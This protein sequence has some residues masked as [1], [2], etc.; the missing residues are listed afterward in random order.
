[1]TKKADLE[2]KF[3]E[4][5]KIKHKAMYGCSLGYKRCAECNKVDAL[6]K[7]TSRSNWC[8]KCS[9][10]RQVN[11]RLA[12]AALQLAETGIAVRKKAGRPPGTTRK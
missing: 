2:L 10:I 3:L 6:E 1:M 7:F 9:A 11:Y 8:K 4:D 5:A 12:R